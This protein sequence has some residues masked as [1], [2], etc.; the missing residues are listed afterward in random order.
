MWSFTWDGEIEKVNDGSGFVLR[1]LVVRRAEDSFLRDTYDPKGEN[2]GRRKKDELEGNRR[3]RETDMTLQW[4]V[5]D[6]M[7]SRKVRTI[8]LLV[9]GLSC[10]SLPTLS[11][12]KMSVRLP[13][14]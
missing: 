8:E 12:G 10:Q 3:E 9:F 4:N 6:F 14:K 13:V 11:F 1:R 7:S 5:T 2:E